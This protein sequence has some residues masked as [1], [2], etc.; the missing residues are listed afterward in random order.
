MSWYLL[1]V[2]S[3][4]DVCSAIHSI[5][6]GKSLT[7]GPFSALSMETATDVRELLEFLLISNFIHIRKSFF[8]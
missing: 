7:I 6:N 8:S 2:S 3:Q 5:Q 4:K 1:P